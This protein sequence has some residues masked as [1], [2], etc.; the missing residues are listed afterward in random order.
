MHSCQERTE[1]IPGIPH[2]CPTR[3]PTYPDEARPPLPS[4]MTEGLGPRVPEFR[5]P[6][7]RRLVRPFPVIAA[8]RTTGVPRIVAAIVSA[9]ATDS[10]ARLSSCWNHGCDIPACPGTKFPWLRV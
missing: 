9:E 5:P 10:E 8:R 4:R 6:P 3:G 1:E 2:R 7:R